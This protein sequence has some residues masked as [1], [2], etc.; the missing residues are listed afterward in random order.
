MKD[1]IHLLEKISLLKYKHEE[2]D[3]LTANDFNI[4]SIL[5]IG[6]NETKLHSKLIAFLLNPKESH[7]QEDKFLKLFLKEVDIEENT[8]NS[9]S[10]Q[11]ILEKNIYHDTD[12]KGFIDIVISDN[13]KNPYTIVIE[14]KIYAGDQDAQLFRY[15]EYAKSKSKKEKIHIVYLTLD[16]TLPSE[17]SLNGIDVEDIKIISYKYDIRNWIDACIKEVALIP[18]L[19]EILNQYRSLIIIL[20]SGNRNQKYMKEIESILKLQKNLPL[21]NDL[22]IALQNIR[23]D[24]QVTFWEKLKDKIEIGGYIT[25]NVWNEDLRKSVEKFNYKS[26]NNKGYGIYILLNSTDEYD[27]YIKIGIYHN[28]YCGFDVSP[29]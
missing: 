12:Y 20:T 25:K 14:N 27:L 16:G 6:S 19:R 1:L 8:I 29:H 5:N 17:E 3:K 15:L 23:V 7:L 18:N 22:E 10:S 11:I 24:T 4:F 21:L 26:K 13:S 2:V 9:I 28:I